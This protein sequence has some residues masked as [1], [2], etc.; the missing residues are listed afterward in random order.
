MERA[1]FRQ[2]IKLLLTASDIRGSPCDS[3]TRSHLASVSIFHNKTETVVGLK[4]ILERLRR[5]KNHVTRRMSLSHS[6][7]IT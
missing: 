5:E 7:N 1:C 6:F 3:D 2:H 4:G